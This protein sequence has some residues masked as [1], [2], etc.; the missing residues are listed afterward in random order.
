M[1]SLMSGTLY[2]YVKEMQ[3]YVKAAITIETFNWNL[4][5]TAL[6]NKFQQV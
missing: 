4:C 1:L 2:S 6:R 3:F 5:A